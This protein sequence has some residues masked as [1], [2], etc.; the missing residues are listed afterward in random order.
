[1]A[2]GDYGPGTTLKPLMVNVTFDEDQRIAEAGIGY[3]IVTPSGRHV[4]SGFTWHRPATGDAAPDEH[5]DA[6][7]AVMNALLQAAAAH[8]GIELPAAAPPPP[9]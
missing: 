6:L 7:Q 1:M 2:Q 5:M 9:D 8:E 3:H 4:P